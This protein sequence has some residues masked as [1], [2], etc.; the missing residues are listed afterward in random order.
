M[1]FIKTTLLEY[2]NENVDNVNLLLD[3]INK[4]GI[5]SLTYDEKRYLDQYNKNQ[6]DS[7]LEDWLFTDDDDD[8]FDLY[9]SKLLF[10]EFEEDEDIFY[11]EKKLKRVINKHLNKKPFTNNA[12]WGG[13]Y[14]WAIDSTS[15]YEGTFLY[16]GDEE[17]LLL[18]RAIN[19]DEDYE[20]EVIKNINNSKQLYRFFNKIS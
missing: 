18:N 7:E 10:D 11:N 5:Q 3:K 1:K 13:G 8:T 19:N 16:L 15:N 17:L 4:S 20:D 9:G 12:D 2:I 6:I 14:V